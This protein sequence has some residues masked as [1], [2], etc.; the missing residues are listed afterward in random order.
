M[1]GPYV[2]RKSKGKRSYKTLLVIAAI[3]AIALVVFFWSYD[4]WYVVGTNVGAATGY[5]YSNSSTITVIV[6][7]DFGHEVLV[8]K[9]IPY[10]PGMSALVAL[11][12]V[13]SVD[14]DSSGFVNAV[15]GV[16]SQY[17]GMGA[18]A[19]PV[20]WFYYVNGMFATV[21]SPSYTMHPGD[22]MRWDYHDWDPNDAMGGMTD[23]IV[24]DLFAGFAYG[25]GGNV[26][27]TYIVDTGGYSEEAQQVQQA[28]TKWGINTMVINVGD[29]TVTEKDD[30]SLVLIGPLN[31]PV[32]SD[33]NN[34]FYQLGLS[35][36]YNGSGVDFYDYKHDLTGSVR[37]CGIV[38]AT[39]SPF[40][41]EG[42]YL[43]T[44]I[45]WMCTGVT[46][47]NVDDSVNLM[48]E[49]PEE[50]ENKFSCVIENSNVTGVP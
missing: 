7:E 45:I 11:E 40:N 50:L 31:A 21:Y 26:P 47:E 17:T 43:D 4:K 35:Y 28:F 39:K 18:N 36:H 5:V 15:N 34:L 10:Q 24:G 9:T 22:V 32:I 38:G 23:D 49:H 30:D 33:V 25:Y 46:K 6:S 41:P 42:S 3:I 16:R 8:N 12:K 19:K 44:N 1:A 14:A 27:P 20:D 29:L 2:S 37:E 48:T 13:S